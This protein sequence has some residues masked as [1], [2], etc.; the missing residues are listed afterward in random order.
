MKAAARDGVQN[1][2]TSRLRCAANGG[3]GTGEQV[4]TG[5]AREKKIPKKNALESG[6]RGGIRRELG[7]LWCV[8]VH[9]SASTGHTASRRGRPRVACGGQFQM[10]HKQPALSSPP[11][12]S[13]FPLRRWASP[14]A[15]P[16]TAFHG[17]GR[18]NL[19][20][21]CAV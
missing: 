18:T 2:H 9:A 8:D 11:L 6:G 4:T 1:K 12:S 7:V 16:S 17:P 19:S 14:P 13:F 10:K 3:P 15:R 20:L 5:H 21:S